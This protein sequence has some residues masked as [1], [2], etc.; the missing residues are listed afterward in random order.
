M[1]FHVQNMTCGGCA[2]GVTKAVRSVDPAAGIEID[3]DA[4][5]VELTTAQP[6]AAL[7]AA[8]DTAGF[9]AVPA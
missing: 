2:R 5:T 9:Q 8:L 3:L 7:I 6:A 1:R 4:R